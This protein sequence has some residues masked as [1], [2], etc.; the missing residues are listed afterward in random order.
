VILKLLHPGNVAKGS[1][2]EAAET[3]RK[4]VRTCRT[5]EV[6]LKPEKN[7]DRS[8]TAAGLT[9]EAERILKAVGPRDR[10][11]VLD[12]K[13]KEHSSPELAKRLQDWMSQGH[14]AVCFAL[15]S[16]CGL[17]D[18]VKS[19]AQERWSFGRLTL[20]HDLARVVLWEQ[21]YRAET[22]L[23]GEPYHK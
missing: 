18:T 13:G 6:Y 9:R 7:Q 1:L 2:H 21:L 10:L 23:R 17:A 8:T 20:P 4:R 5:E 16:P 15:G 12:P 3:Y 14:R 19:A 22:I 11:I